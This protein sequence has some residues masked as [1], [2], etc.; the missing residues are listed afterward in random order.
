MLQALIKFKPETEEK[1]YEY[2]KISSFSIALLSSITLSLYN[3][4]KNAFLMELLGY[5][6][7]GYL[8]L[9]LFIAKG[10]AVWHHVF[11]LIGG[12]T[13]IKC[14]PLESQ[15]LIFMPIFSTEITTVFL[16]I[17]L[18]MD[19]YKEKKNVIFRILYGINDIL[20]VSL[21]FKLRIYNFYFNLI[22]KPEVY[23]V[24]NK[25]IINVIDIIL[26]YVGVYGLFILNIYWFS[27]I[28]KKLYKQIIM[29]L[30]PFL[31]SKRVAEA[32]LTVSFFI[33]FY[34]AYVNYSVNIYTNSYYLLDLFGIFVL[35]V[36]SGNYH[37][38][39]YKYMKNNEV[40]NVT[41]NELL[42]P[43]IYD[44]YAIQLR[45]FLALT[46]ISLANGTSAKFIYLSGIYHIMSFLSFN[47]NMIKILFNNSKII[48][49]E[50]DISKMIIK[51]LVTITSIPCLLDTILIICYHTNN[52]CLK[53]EL[54]FI[55]IIIGTILSVKPFYNLNNV[56]LHVLFLYQ[57]NCITNYALQTP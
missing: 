56:L 22:H 34:I 24:L 12:Y 1:I 53:T 14:I 43:F 10:D 13:S 7:C 44:K 30:T 45:S 57:T 51:K 50:S 40:I 35:S 37:Y 36:A 28:C 31:D 3:Q 26:G 55:S 16:I 17:K 15:H 19:D 20:F 38:S 9:D 42:E 4:T 47:M 6:L 41:T 52:V 32:M 54:F 25:N 49:D 8:F 11:S 23:I 2:E 27:I 46:T 29:K 33:N 39:K 18:W 21:F 48:Y 5:T